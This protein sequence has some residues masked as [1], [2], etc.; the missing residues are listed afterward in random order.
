MKPAA[1]PS[2]SSAAPSA[3]SSESEVAAVARPPSRLRFLLVVAG[4]LGI[5]LG[6]AWVASGSLLEAKREEMRR[7]LEARLHALAAGRARAVATWADGVAELGRS[8]TR[9]ELV[10]LFVTETPLAEADPELARALAEERP[11]LRLLLDE[12]AA[13]HDFR[14][15]YLFDTEG[16]LLLSDS[17]A[18][19]PGRDVVTAIRDLVR[20]GGGQRFRLPGEDPETL[21]LEVLLPIPQ[22]QATGAAG[23]DPA[24]VL[25]MQLPAMPVLLDLLRTPGLDLPGEASMLLFDGGGGRRLLAV[26]AETT[27]L[28]DGRDLLPP[29]PEM[30][31]GR[32]GGSE[33]A[34]GL[35]ATVP[36]TDWRLIQ[37]MNAAAADAPLADYRRNLLTYGVL[38]GLVLVLA[39]SSWWWSVQS[40]HQHALARQYRRYSRDIG[41]QRRLLSA[42]TENLPEPLALYGRDGLC[43]Y[44]NPAFQ[45]LAGVPAGVSAATLQEN[46]PPGL[47][48]ALDRLAKEAGRS[49]LAEE[50]GVE[51]DLRQ[52][53]RIFDL[54][55]V[56]PQEEI[57]EAVVVAL[58]DVTERVLRQQERERMI[59]R[60]VAALVRAV[61]KTDPYLLGHSQRMA[62]VARAIG[63][64]LGLEERRLEMLRVGAQLSQIG[65]LFVPR[66]LLRKEGRHTPEEQERMRKHAE[67]LRDLLE[68]AELPAT[69]RLA[70]G[71]MYERLDGS[72][73]PDGLRGD[74]IC[75]EARILAVADVFCARTSP[76]SY[77]EALPARSVLGH[78][79]DHPERYDPEVVG[80]LARLL[81]RGLLSQET[82]GAGRQPRN[83]D[84]SD[85]ASEPA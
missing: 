24:G 60:T 55:A 23:D 28:L 6:A 49:G 10:R 1:S 57:G 45:R 81:E 15:V 52:H 69:V 78:L 20:S 38:A 67:H 56:A 50:Q 37:W 84:S 3:A 72:G 22:P 4:L 68:E 36:G 17:D 77:R 71:Q 80:A 16:G 85:L 79:W 54:I 75:L 76:R 33:P 8:L 11:Y 44:G 25:V 62:A 41:R 13:T 19:R 18:P 21:R 46:L 30:V 65:K 27:S 70:L 83:A 51:I 40:R 53:R 64:A 43:L 59:G 9:A 7:A 47:R 42:I 31:L 48:R 39:A 61:E 73:Y 29:G 34:Y 32:I 35:A 5:V 14:A 63:T 58:R 2:A 74:A 26:G 82:G 66:S 12:L